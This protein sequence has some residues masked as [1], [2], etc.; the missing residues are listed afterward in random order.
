MYFMVLQGKAGGGL[1]PQLGRESKLR[2]RARN[3]LQW[4][5]VSL[6]VTH[7]RQV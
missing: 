4:I 3:A 6:A 5:A 1:V 2:A 7:A